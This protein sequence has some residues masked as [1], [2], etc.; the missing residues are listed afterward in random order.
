VLALAILL[1][2][3]LPVILAL[4]KFIPDIKTFREAAFV[5]WFGKTQ[6][7]S[8]NNIGPIGV[9]AIFISTLAKTRL[10]PINANDGDT[11]QVDLLTETIQP[12]VAFL[13]LFSV[14]FRKLSCFWTD[15]D[16]LSIPFFS[17]GRRVHSITHTWS[18]N[19]SMDARGE[20]PAWTSHA[21]RIIPGQDITINRDDD[22]EEGDMGVRQES[23]QHD[24][25]LREKNSLGDNS[26][27]SR[28]AAGQDMEMKERNSQAS[29]SGSS[30]NVDD[31]DGESGGSQTGRRT[32]PLAEYREGNHL[33]IERTG[34]VDG[35]VSLSHPALI[36][37]LK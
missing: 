14:F 21:R 24:R 16:G 33:I 35:E 7:S 22:P 20:E 19:P 28:T 23:D 26:S 8:T 29:G 36:S 11:S 3:R 17:L 27:G 13:V 31:D 32:P 1:I 34:G 18:R 15:V 30:G 25:S 6:T 37:R 12:I 2:R 9:G 4:Y 5:G 10:P